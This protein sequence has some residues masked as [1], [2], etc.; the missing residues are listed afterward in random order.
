MVYHRK[1]VWSYLTDYVELVRKERRERTFMVSGRH[2]D[3]TEH[4]MLGD[5]GGSVPLDENL[6]FILPADSLYLTYSLFE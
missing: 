3:G 4:D 5:N 6:C 1:E 2:R